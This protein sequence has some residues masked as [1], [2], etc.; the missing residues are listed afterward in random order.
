MDTQE[1]IESFS[2]LDGTIINLPTSTPKIDK[3][4]KATED[5]STQSKENLND[6][7]LSDKSDKHDST[8]NT[9]YDSDNS[10]KNDGNNNNNNSSDSCDPDNNSNIIIIAQSI[11]LQDALRVVPEYDGRTKSLSLF[12]EGCNKT[13]GMIAAK[14]NVFKNL[15]VAQIESEMAHLRWVENVNRKTNP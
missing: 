6:P 11:T 9:N 10:D 7:S 4:N 3:I 8:S 14:S 13:K 12:L 5:K 1:S 2:D 15:K